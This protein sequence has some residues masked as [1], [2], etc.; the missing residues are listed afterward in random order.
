ML[1]GCSGAVPALAPVVD[2]AGRAG[3]DPDVAAAA[4]GLTGTESWVAVLLERGLRVRVI[5]AATG[6]PES[7]IR[8]HLKR[9]FARHGLTRPTELVRPVRSLAGAAGDGR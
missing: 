9:M 2:S 5:A 8:S 6:R 7:T 4:L 3:V 1:V